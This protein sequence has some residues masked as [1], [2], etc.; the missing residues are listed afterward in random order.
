[1]GEQLQSC[2]VKGNA[3]KAATQAILVAGVHHDLLS[4]RNWGSVKK[5]QETLIKK[6]V[7]SKTFE[8]FRQAGTIVKELLDAVCPSL[9]KGSAAQADSD[10]AHMLE[11]TSVLRAFL[12]GNKGATIT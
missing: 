1:M 7:T 4:H 6:N 12:Y 10:F 8:T 11:W 3:V 2:I 9:S 5:I